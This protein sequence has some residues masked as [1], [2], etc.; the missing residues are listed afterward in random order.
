MIKKYRLVNPR[1][2]GMYQVQ[3]L[4]DFGDVVA[5]DIGGF[6]SGEHN[7]SHYDTCWIYDEAE[8]MDDARVV[9]SAKVMGKSNIKGNSIVG[10]Y[11]VVTGT[12]TIKD[13]SHICGYS[14]VKDV[15]IGDHCHIADST[16]KDPMYIQGDF[17]RITITDSCLYWEGCW[18]RITGA[19]SFFENLALDE[20]KFFRLP[21]KGTEDSVKTI[22]KQYAALKDVVIPFIIPMAK[23]HQGVE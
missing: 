3:A 19:V 4:R 20:R 13:H 18:I 17:G 10:G 9:D 8:V 12:S 7:L 6:V 14:Y 2:G 1:T 23:I 22:E 11:S 21:I 16:L 15:C 5:G